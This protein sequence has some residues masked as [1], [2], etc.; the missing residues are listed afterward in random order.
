LYIEK[1]THQLLRAQ[2]GVSG[3]RC[4]DHLDHPAI[5]KTSLGRW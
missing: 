2:P 3:V 4:S 1:R 5:R